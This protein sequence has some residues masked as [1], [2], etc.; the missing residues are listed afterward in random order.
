MKRQLVAIEEKV[1]HLGVTLADVQKRVQRIDSR[2][3][4]SHLREALKH[5]LSN[6]VDG[7]NI[8]LERLIP[9]IT[10]FQHLEET[11]EGGLLFNFGVSLSS[12]IREHL[13]GLLDLLYGIRRNVVIAHNATVGNVPEYVI[14]HR[15][16]GDYFFASSL[17]D[18][19]QCAISQGRKDLIFREFAESLASKI[20]QHFTF[21]EQSDGALFREFAYE[22]CC[23]PQWQAMHLMPSTSDSISLSAML[24]KF[25]FNYLADDAVETAV[26]YRD[27]WLE[28]SDASLL[29]CVTKELEGIRDGYAEV[30]YPEHDGDQIIPIEQTLFSLQHVESAGAA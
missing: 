9:L 12:D 27:L 28:Q 7:A 29:F 23:L 30:F 16:Y 10:D 20:V 13:K 19:T 3:A 6:S 14:A 24:D 2:V 11:I 26:N 8:N 18:I 25:G 5:A 22:Q 21:A 15:R 1:D 4:E 17:S